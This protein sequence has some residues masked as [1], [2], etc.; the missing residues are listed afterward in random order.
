MSSVLSALWEW[1]FPTECEPA[2]IVC[3]RDNNNTMAGCKMF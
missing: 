3:S 1:V 2:I